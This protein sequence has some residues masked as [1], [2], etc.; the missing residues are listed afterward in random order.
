MITPAQVTGLPLNSVASTAGRQIPALAPFVPLVLALL[1]D[2]AA[3]GLDAAGGLR[4]G[5]S[6]FQFLTSNGTA[7]DGGAPIPGQPARKWSQ[8]AGP[9]A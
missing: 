3:R 8:P 7:P 4:P 9:P 6:A 1:V 2:G 5:L